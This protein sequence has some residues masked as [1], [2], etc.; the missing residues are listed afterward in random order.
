MSAVMHSEQLADHDIGRKKLQQ[1]LEE[2]DSENEKAVINKML[3]FEEKHRAV[4]ERFGRYPSRNECLGRR[5][6][7]EEEV[8]IMDGPG[9]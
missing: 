5:S 4:V 6:T 8:S 7:D 9:W 1:A 3:D 2:A